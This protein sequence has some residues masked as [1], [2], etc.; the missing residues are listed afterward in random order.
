M[1]TSASNGGP[2]GSPPLLPDWYNPS[3][4]DEDNQE[5]P[6]DGN[7]DSGE[8]N[9][10]PGQNNQNTPTTEPDHTNNSSKWGQSKGA[11]T[12]L[13]NSRS[14]SSVKKAGRKYVNSLG[15]SRGATRAAAQGRITGS[16]YANFLGNLASGGISGAL[17]N[18]GLENFVGKSSEEIC[19]AIADAI[20]PIGTT[21][22]EAISRDALISTL[23]SLYNRIQENGNDFTDIDSLS[24]D[25]IKETLIDFVSN[26]VFNKWMYELGNAVEKGSV[27]ESEA[28]NLENEVK[29]LIYTETFEH[30]R[31]IPVET[32]NIRDQAN[33]VMIDDIFQTAYS[34]LEQ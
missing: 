33:E 8:N 1:G 13:S 20:A 14:G 32:F 6:Q 26:F 34:T 27:T 7:D 9:D 2:K 28:I 18:L 21:N 23:D 5:T 17:Q 25:Q 31:D 12:R 15:G 19:I 11:L 29:D 24:I 30:Y 3:Q 10:S 22:D 4:S 16:N